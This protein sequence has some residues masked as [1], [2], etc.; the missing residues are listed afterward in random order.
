MTAEGEDVGASGAGAASPAEL[1]SRAWAALA[2][3]RGCMADMLDATS[4]LDDGPVRGY[5]EAHVALLWDVSFRRIEPALVS[6]DWEGAPS[7]ERE[8]AREWIERVSPGPVSSADPAAV[9]RAYAEETE[10]DMTRWEG[11]R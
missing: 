5:F 9:L 7:T 4:G 6:F 3:F 2:V 10:A 11:E 1:L 8:T